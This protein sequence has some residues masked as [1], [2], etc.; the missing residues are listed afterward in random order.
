M[1]RNGGLGMIFSSNNLS[2]KELSKVI[3]TFVSANKSRIKTYFSDKI[4]FFYF[5]LSVQNNRLIR[6]F[7]VSKLSHLKIL[8]LSGNHISMMEGLKELKLLTW[9]GLSNNHIKAIEQL[10]QVNRFFK[11]K[12]K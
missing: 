9:L 6:M 8:N 12:T 1:E 11:F 10:N 5:Q 2:I 3:I 4:F 7:Q